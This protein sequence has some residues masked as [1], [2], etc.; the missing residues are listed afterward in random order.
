MKQG[1]IDLT[2]E[3]LTSILRYK[4]HS[5]IYGLLHPVWYSQVG[6]IWSVIVRF[7]KLNP[8]RAEWMVPEASSCTIMAAFIQQKRGSFYSRHLE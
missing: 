5:A 4:F 2:T 6:G 8:L 3:A 7:M 1:S